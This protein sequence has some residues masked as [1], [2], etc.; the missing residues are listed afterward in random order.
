MGDFS[1][2]DDTNYPKIPTNN[3][4]TNS[5]DFLTPYKVQTG[6]TRGVQTVGFGG[7]KIDGANNRITVGANISLDGNT[8][9][10][11]VGDD[12]VIDGN[13]DS[14]TIGNSITLNGST[15]LITVTSDDAN[16]L[17]MG[18]VSTDFTGI[19]LA[20][21]STTT[22][23]LGKDTTLTGFSIKDSNVN[24]VTLGRS[25]NNVGLLFNDS[26]YDRIF[27]GKN[28]L[29]NY[30]AKLSQTGY[31]VKTAANSQLIWSSEFNMFKIVATGTLTTPAFTVNAGAGNY[32]QGDGSITLS[33]GLGISPVLMAY[34]FDLTGLSEAAP[35]P[36]SINIVTG[37]GSAFWA[38]F[39]GY[40]TNTTLYL[41][42]S[43]VTFNVLVNAPAVDIK[44]Y[45]LQ[46]TAH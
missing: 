4:Q 3:P 31:D 5:A 15:D 27:I 2:I 22:I 43:V 41:Q 44:Y 24:V 28:S 42:Q 17:S 38:D 30:V 36:L 34:A 23:N 11:K 8:E 14:I 29:G 21:T 16:L 19:R 18:T 32:G 37:T 33:H 26:T 1:S 35:I 25:N 45:L 40:T 13:A 39:V 10:I 46:E 9:Q 6:N 20:D 12:I 7:T